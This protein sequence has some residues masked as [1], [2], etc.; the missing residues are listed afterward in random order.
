M[1]VI[2]HETVSGYVFNAIDP[3]IHAHTPQ[4]IRFIQ[5][6]PVGS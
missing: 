4:L 3:S 2:Y 6:V 1:L 5:P